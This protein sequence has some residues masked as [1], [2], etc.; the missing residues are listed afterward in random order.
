M[1]AEVFAGLGTPHALKKAH[2]AAIKHDELRNDAEMHQKVSDA[3]QRTHPK[4]C[5]LPEFFSLI[6]REN[7]EWWTETGSKLPE[8][9]LPE[10]R[11]K[12]RTPVLISERILPLERKARDMLIDRFCKEEGIQAVRENIENE[13]S[14][15]RIYL[16]L[17]HKSGQ[18]EESFSL[19]NFP[20]SLEKIEEVGSD[21]FFLAE[22]IAEG[23]AILHW[24]AKIDARDVEFVLGSVA[25]DVKVKEGE[26]LTDS[27]VLRLENLSIRNV[28]ESEVS[29]ASRIGDLLKSDDPETANESISGTAVNHEN[30]WVWV[31]DFNQCED[32][33][34][35]ENGCIKAAKAFWDND[36]YYPRPNT[37]QD[38]E[39][40]KYFQQKYLHFS[41]RILER[42]NKEW[43]DLPQ[44]FIEKVV[45]IGLSRIAGSSVAA[46]PPRGIPAAKKGTAKKARVYVQ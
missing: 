19:R 33:T 11:T 18:K 17:R 21:K 27:G 12:E 14:L 44:L 4:L 1:C 20:Y 26:L 28:G 6:E 25:E 13:D 43:K 35:D 8:S 7:D 29:E 39:L 32:I 34:M 38:E 10:A 23:L 2:S 5:H 30:L 9:K 40:W 22:A 3:F 16:G 37:E 36:P 46:G 15:L 42:E 41:S 24:G 31:L 45:E